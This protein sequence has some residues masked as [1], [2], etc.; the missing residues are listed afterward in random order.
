T[1]S[2]LRTAEHFTMTVSFVIA[3]AFP[4]RNVEPECAEYNP[5]PAGGPAME[6]TP[7]GAAHEASTAIAVAEESNE[8][9][10]GEKDK[11]EELCVN[12]IRFLAVDAVEKAK[13]GHPGTP[14]GMADKIGRASCRERVGLRVGEVC[15]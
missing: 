6:Q 13:S 8:P 2:S 12:T 11:L 1:F 4:K 9:R 14:M 15:I 3:S 10:I 5:P 7:G